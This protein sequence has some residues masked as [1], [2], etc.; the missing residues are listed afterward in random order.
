MFIK[1]IELNNFRIYKGKNTINLLP[2]KDKNVIIISGKNG[3]GK[4]TFLMS[5][6]WC[7]YGKQMENVDEL[8]KKEIVDK[9]GY[10]KYISN[11]LNRL[12]KSEGETKFSVSVTFT[13]VKIPDITCNEIKITRTYDIVT[14]SNDK[15]EVLIDGYQ[16]EL[17]QDLTTEGKQDGEEIFIREFILPIEIAKFFFFDAEK[18]VSLAEINSLEQRKLLSKA[19]T[20]V[21]GIKKY[22]DLKDQLE[23]IQD[24][25][26]KKSAKPQELVEFNNVDTDIKNLEITIED[27][28]H[29]IQKLNQEKVE[30]QS[31][32][33]E[34]QMKLIRE[35]NLM[36]LEQLTALKIEEKE[37]DDKI[38]SLQ[39]DLKELFD[40]IP[41][42]LAGETLME[43]SNQLENEKQYRENKYRQED[44]GDKTR[45]IINDIEKER[46]RTNFMF[47]VEIRNFYETLIKKLVKKHFFSDV[48][49]LS[50]TF[51][52][53]HDFSDAQNNELNA[54]I[55]NL[56]YSFKDLFSRLN[57]NYSKTKNELDAIRRKI[58]NAEKDADDEYITDLRA[59]KSA[60]DNRVFSI[61]EQ[62]YQ[63]SEKIGSFKNDRKASKQ[64]QEELRKKI[65]DSR[66]YSDKDEKT[67]DII[68]KLKNF[69]KDFKITTK[70][71]LEENI[72]GELNVLMHKKGFIKKVLVDINQAGDDVDINLLNEREEKIDRG[73][74]SMGERQMYASAL[75][76]ALVDESDIEFPVFI[77]SPMQKFD[78]EHAENVIKSFYPNVSKQV[79]LF[80][81]IHKEL[82]EHEFEL[83]KPNINRS[84]LI[85]NTSMDTSEFIEVEE[86]EN[87]IKTYDELYAN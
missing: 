80:P 2:E 6:V 55:N 66:L 56:N 79:I 46:L 68:N 27:I 43:V 37:L 13:D 61:E 54:M 23:N 33:N 31:E 87:L 24:D 84:Y 69:I 49:E 5:L 32:S 75:L 85:H 12:A 30:K 19:Y 16:N 63:L 36:T 40:L 8:Y 77:D 72:L 65:D 29:Q 50:V 81:L 52:P 47:D 38:N 78:K 10:G 9:G 58:R 22:E 82:T 35:G 64:R 44:V 71:K 53:L 21:L 17:I 14:S 76:K 60:L 39:N 34:I 1:E 86:A 20:E 18:I 15:V 28:E 70:N 57:D 11:S 67:Q 74:L 83:L 26:R 62:I 73:T 7:L 3:F 41:F 48:P 51:E 25:Y 59:K 42:G 4:T 45:L